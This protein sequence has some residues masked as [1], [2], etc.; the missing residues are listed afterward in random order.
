MRLDVAISG[1]HWNSKEC[2]E[3]NPR[4]QKKLIKLLG[5]NE[6]NKKRGLFQPNDG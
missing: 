2:S 1:V 6:L 3:T 5:R 4:A